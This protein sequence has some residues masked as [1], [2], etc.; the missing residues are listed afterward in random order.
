MNNQNLAQDLT[1]KKPEAR[2]SD[3]LVQKHSSGI[4]HVSESSTANRQKK[5]REL[6]S[7]FSIQFRGYTFMNDAN[8]PQQVIEDNIDFLIGD[9]VVLDKALGNFDGIYEITE[10]YENNVDVYIGIGILTLN[11]R[12]VR[13]A[14]T[15]ELNAK[16]RL[17]EAE[18]A[19]AE[20]P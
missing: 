12:F 19:L 16:R 18:Q 10:V 4:E 2:L 7:G 14:S 6:R 20:V 17:T 15:T 1:K 9:A 13:S 11:K 5:A 8:L 3:F